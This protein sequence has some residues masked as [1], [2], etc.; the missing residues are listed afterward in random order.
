[1]KYSIGL[2]IGIT[3]VGY[4]V[5]LLDDN[6]EPFKIHKMGSRIF[7][8]AE[9]PKDGSPLAEPRR[10]NRGMRRRLR[11]KRFRKERIRQLI[12]AT[13][14]MTQSEIDEIYSSKREL[15]DIYQLRNEAL[16]RLLNKEEFVRLI[17]HFSQ[18]RGFKSNRKIDSENKKS[19]AGKMLTAI[20]TN[21]KLMKEGL[22]RTIGE[23][24]YKDKTFADAKR[25][26]A[27]DYKLSF[28]R[29]DYCEEIRLIFDAQRGFGSA[30]ATVNFENEFFEIYLSQRSFD[31]GPGGNS[32]YGGNQ[33][34]KML[35]KCTF[36]KDEPK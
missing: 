10:I 15:S 14:I 6:D 19:E 18:R 17:I 34:L 20:E 31:E 16:D 13:G 27:D 9:N 2:D 11:R 36:E 25:N 29:E 3:S 33:I 22:Y 7:D 1:M 23:M 21:Q 30:Y 4:A 28:N 12:E 5:M 8:I 24:L 26:K 35:G 32:I